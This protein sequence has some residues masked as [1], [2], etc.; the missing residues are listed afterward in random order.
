[1][2]NKKIWS[3]LRITLLKRYNKRASLFQYKLDLLQTDPTTHVTDNFWL[4]RTIDEVVIELYDLKLKVNNLIQ[5]L[6]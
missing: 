2:Q 5:K 6:K 3:K 4:Y 1:M